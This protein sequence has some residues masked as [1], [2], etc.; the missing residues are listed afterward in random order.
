MGFRP[1]RCGMENCVHK[2]V[3]QSVTGYFIKKTD[4]DILVKRNSCPKEE[5]K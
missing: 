2:P 3:V 5:S 4:P 1:I